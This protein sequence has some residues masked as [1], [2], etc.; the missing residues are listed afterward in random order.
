M[1]DK[2]LQKL[3]NLAPGEFQRMHS[4]YFQGLPGGE[5]AFLPSI[6]RLPWHSKQ[7]RIVGSE[8]ISKILRAEL[9]KI[10]ELI[11]IFII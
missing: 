6:F 5:I 11:L 9:I 1:D 4:G 2:A 3:L 10:L 8:E 7:P